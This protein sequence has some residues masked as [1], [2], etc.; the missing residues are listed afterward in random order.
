MQPCYLAAM[1][2]AAWD[3]WKIACAALTNKQ[4]KT[5]FSWKHLELPK[6]DLC[7]GYLKLAQWFWRRSRTCERDR[8]QMQWV[9]RKSY[10]SFQLRWARKIQKRMM[11]YWCTDLM[12]LLC[13]KSDPILVLAE[14][15]NSHPNR[16]STGCLLGADLKSA[17]NSHLIYLL[18]GVD[19]NS[20]KSSQFMGLLLE[21]CESKIPQKFSF[22]SSILRV[23]LK[24][25]QKFS[26]VSYIYC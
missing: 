24:S 3:R 25:R 23:D 11:Y 14:S 8:W 26:S 1:M 18:F 5:N 20:S 22:N 4:T 7:Q 21:I 9:I 6:D 13:E 2:T 10:F 16:L 19:L 12:S 15:L 17:K